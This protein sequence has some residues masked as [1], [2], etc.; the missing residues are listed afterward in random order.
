MPSARTTD[1]LLGVNNKLGFTNIRTGVAYTYRICVLTVLLADGV[2]LGLRKMSD[3]C[4]IHTFWELLRIEKWHVREEQLRER[5]PRSLK[6]NPNSQWRSSGATGSTF[7]PGQRKKRL[8]SSTRNMI[9]LQVFQP[10]AKPP[11]NMRRSRR[12]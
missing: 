3:A 2:N 1:I 8:T 7:L 11:T 10:T 9:T 12:K 4:D 6:P 5:L